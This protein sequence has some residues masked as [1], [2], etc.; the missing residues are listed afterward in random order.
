MDTACD[1]AGVRDMVCDPDT[2]VFAR[3]SRRSPQKFADYIYNVDTIHYGTTS[4]DART[5]LCETRLH[6]KG[7]AAQK[8]HSH[9]KESA[10]SGS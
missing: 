7:E 10:L 6:T 9:R 1:F 4:H 2:D 3:T 5:Y 8:I